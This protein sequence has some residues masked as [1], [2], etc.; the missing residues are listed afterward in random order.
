MHQ[1]IRFFQEGLK[2]LKTVGTITRS[3]PFLCRKV[4]D[5]VD[6]NQARIIAELGA[7]DGV[8]TRHILP[9]LHP[10]GKLLAFEV[11]P[12]M[13]EHLLQIDDPRLIVVEDS[14]E[15]IPVYLEKE[16]LQQVDYILS[17]IPFV[18]LPQEL[19]LNILAT[20]RDVLR[21]GGL[22]VQVHYS[23]LAKKLYEETFGNVRVHFVP[24]NIPPA[25]V[26]V[27]ERI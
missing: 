2:N 12:Q 10:E 13:S 15:H 11:L 21:P 24:W 26:L 22:F 14:A 19:S 9:R 17:A 5:M 16:N 25:F 3:S 4:T 23:L 18:V 8:I 20:C 1:S 7:G 27:S 6:F